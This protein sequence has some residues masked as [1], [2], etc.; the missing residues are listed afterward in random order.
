MRGSGRLQRVH[1]RLS[2]QRPTSEALP[3]SLERRMMTFRHVLFRWFRK[4]PSQGAIQRRNRLSAFG[5]SGDGLRKSGHGGLTPGTFDLMVRGGTVVTAAGSRRAD[6][7]IRGETIVAVEA[8][9]PVESARRVTDASGLLVL[10]GIIDV[11]T[12]TRIASD[13]EPDRFFQDSVAA[14]FGGTTTF[15]A[16]NNP[17]TGISD[18]A[19]RT[20]RG[21]VEEWLARTTGDSAVD[22]GLSAVIT[23]QQVDP[24][25]D[26]VA[27]LAAGISTFKAFM[28]YSFGV[29]E[30][31]LGRLL[32]RLAALGGLLQVHCEDRSQLAAG[33]S[34]E[35]AAGRAAPRFHADSRRPEVEAAGTRRAI[36][37]AAEAGAHLYAVHLSSAEALAAVREAKAAGQL[38]IAETCPHYLALDRS[39]YELPVDEAIRY[40]ISPPLRARSDIDALWGGLADG[41]LDLVATDHVP[42][43]LDLEK[44]YDGQ[45]FD[46]IS[47]GAPGI[48][49]LLSV[50]YSEGVAAGRITQERLVD[51]LATTPARVFGLRR[52]GAVEVGRDADLVLFDTGARRVIQASDLHHTSDY[53]PYEG[54]E[55]RGAVRHVLVRGHD[56]IRDGRF[57]GV[58]G[59]GRYQERG[60]NRG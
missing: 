34:R 52:K 2:P 10:P 3:G 12:H 22:F 53:S 32:G 33:I 13:A 41:S 37:L 43:R 5:H 24:E 16:F 51:T 56:V 29:D 45:A 28:V 14:A 57:V 48:E 38:V 42:D 46:V 23:G 21:G 60:G 36:A 17:G 27:A 18:A 9:L 50:V 8:G 55:V 59:F 11:H 47:N 19:Q 44:R 25:A 20:L 58:R 54:L 26:L 35:L 6:V 15:L 40:V 4:G 1:R 39:R 49:T 30:R 31:L 7:A